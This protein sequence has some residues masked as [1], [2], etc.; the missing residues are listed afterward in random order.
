MNR[1]TSARASFKIGRPGLKR[2]RAVAGMLAFF[3]GMAVASK[4][5]A[6]AVIKP[7]SD[8][9]TLQIKAQQTP[10]PQLLEQIAQATGVSLHYGI[11]QDLVLDADCEEAAFKDV[12]ACLFGADLGL[13]V[14]YSA[15][16]R[17][18]EAWLF[19]INSNGKAIATSASPAARPEAADTGNDELDQQLAAA[20]SKD[21]ARRSEALSNLAS[22][23]GKDNPDVRRTLVEALS[24]QNPAIRASAI[25]SLAR[26]EGEAA[27]AELQQALQ[28]KDVSVRLAAVDNAGSNS[29]FLQQALNDGNEMV[30]NVAAGKLIVLNRNAQRGM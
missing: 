28:D 25:A 3:A 26:R 4:S 14:R 22:A 21:P 11:P 7:N 16:G 6:Q 24:D 1:I 5:A 19:G 2:L 12:M 18:E 10:A 15:Q 8:R 27:G 20:R 30:R 17:P 13:A 29:A 23:G 9:A